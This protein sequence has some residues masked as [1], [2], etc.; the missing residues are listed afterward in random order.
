MK[1]LHLLAGMLGAL[2]VVATLTTSA[3][4]VELRLDPAHSDVRDVASLQSGARTFVNHCLNCHS[5]SILLYNRLD[6]MCLKD[7]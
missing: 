2:A 4:G 7:L 6:V 1:P 5:A 3:A